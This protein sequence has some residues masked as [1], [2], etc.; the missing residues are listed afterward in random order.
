VRIVITSDTH[1]HPEWAATLK[2]F[3][4][5]IAALQPDCLILAGD[6][7]EGT[8]NFEQ[9]LILFEALP[10][11]RLILSGNHDLWMRGKSDS[12]GLWES[13]LPDLT[14]KHGAI[15]LEGENWICKGIGVSG[16]NGWYDYSARDPKLPLTTEQYAQMK[17]IVMMD[18]RRMRWRWTDIEFANLIGQAFES[19]LSTL[20]SDPNIREILVATHVPPF[21]EGIT[22]RPDDPNWNMSN[23]YFGNLTLGKR[24][25]K[26]PKVRRVVSGHTHIGKHA[27]V[28]G[29][30]MHVINADYGYPAYLLFDYPD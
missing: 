17:P 21:E 28:G 27:Q 15:W 13:I 4:N 6:V 29:I 2:D 11:P 12:Q 23:A 3:V 30:D 25:T 5:K 1:Y 10:C 26:Y 7:G 20:E 9:M 14:R 16:T 8:D 19:R 18:G 22:R 24:I